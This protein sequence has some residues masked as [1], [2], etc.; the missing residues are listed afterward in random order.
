MPDEENESGFR[1]TDRRGRAREEESHP[2]QD[3]D[4]KRQ[5]PAS[6]GRAP[7]ASRI[8]A[9]PAHPDAAPAERS[10]AGLFV[11][12]A[13][14]A[15]TALGEAPDPTSGQRHRDPEQAAELIDLLMLLR[16]K[17]EGH[18]TPEETALLEDVLYDLHMRYTQVMTSFGSRSGPARP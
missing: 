10:L 14:S 1:V 12:L 6:E 17:T 3:A 9:A 7:R 16:E 11:M 15:L 4:A 8:D 5:P 2:P 13:T 18:R